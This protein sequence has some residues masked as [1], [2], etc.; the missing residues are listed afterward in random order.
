MCIR[1]RHQVP[2]NVE[3]TVELVKQNVLEIVK[4]ARLMSCMFG[5]DKT[6]RTPVNQAVLDLI[7]YASHPSK[8]ALQDP[9]WMPWL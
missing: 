5:Q 9:T 3:P 4:R 8:L 2:K 7:N 1:D 6:S